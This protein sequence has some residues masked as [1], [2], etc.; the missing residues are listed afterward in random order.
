MFK[1][2]VSALSFSPHASAQLSFYARRLA[3]EKVTRVFSAIGAVLIVLLQFSTIAAP[4]A[5]VNAASPND[6]IYGGYVSKADLL[7]KYDSS[8]E[9]QALYKYFGISRAD[10]AAST[11]VT[12]NTRDKSLNSV[13]RIQHAA[14]D[15]AFTVGSHEY[16]ARYLYQFDTGGNVQSGS[17]YDVLQGTTASGQYFAIMFRCG[18]VV[19]KKFPTPPP[20]P[21]P[22]PKPTPTPTKAPTPTPKPTA[23][24][25][26]T[27]TP[28]PSPK[29]TLACVQLTGNVISGTAPLTVNY[30][31]EGSSS[32]QTITKY[33]FDFGDSSTPAS[34][35]SRT[36]THTYKTAG[37]FTAA[38]TVTGSLGTTTP[39]I[40]PCTYKVVVTP[41]PAAFTKHK[42]ALN[43]TQNVDAT[44][45]SANPGDRIM[46]SL[47]TTNIGGVSDSYTVVEHL[48]DILEYANVSDSDGGLV[49]KDG[50][51]TWNPVTIAPGQTITKTFTVTVKDPVPS[52]P[53]GLS[54]PFSFDLRMDNVYGNAVQV[55]VTPPLP[56][57]IETAAAQLPATG[58]GTATTI[59]LVFSALAIFFYFRNRQLA[60]EIKL[61]R[62]DYQGG[63]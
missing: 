55:H 56:K 63:A 20:T 8:A 16:Y 61:I 24:P 52:T 19:F 22:T 48:A 6:I 9:L 15:R 45:K 12:I 31:G 13:G 49:D 54:D 38:L 42:S 43:L 14:S 11:K 10:I 26:V 47:T 60:A 18:N 17:N 34:G 7:N 59:V 27:P 25:K 40:A 41:T 28:T 46:Y 1:D 3:K 62:H 53:A 4:P 37:T 36:A 30:T 50:I 5:N 29:P 21:T 33:T 51:L 32:G 44:T 35:A 23:T 2:I 58:A 57:Q 39:V